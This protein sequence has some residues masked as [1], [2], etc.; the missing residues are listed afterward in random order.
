V[1]SGDWVHLHF[2]SPK[3]GLGWC[4]WNHDPLMF[5]AHYFFRWNFTYISVICVRRKLQ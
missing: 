3:L 1:K 5:A 4:V 2:W